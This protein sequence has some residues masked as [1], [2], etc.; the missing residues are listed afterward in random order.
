[1]NT[2]L[3]AFVLLTI[4]QITFS[5]DLDA[6][7]IRNNDKNVDQ[8]SG[9]FLRDTWWS[10]PYEYAWAMQFAEENMVVLDAACG[11]SHPFKW[12]LAEK[13][14]HVW[15]CDTDKR[16]CSISKIIQETFDDLGHSAKTSLCLKDDIFSKINLVCASILR[17]PQ[18]MPL[19]DRIFCIST[20]E[21]LSSLDRKKTLQEFKKFLAPDGFIVLTVDYP[22]ITPEVL[23]S[24]C[25]E[26]GLRMLGN[27]E[28]GFPSE[29]ALTSQGL[30]VY[31]CVLT[32]K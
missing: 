32:H 22:V 19:F 11:I 8:V 10:R 26:I 30:H 3:F 9:I 13:C 28:F 23:A 6:R 16:I 1:M 12:Y 4:S 15:A 20:L 24:C 27:V 2:K 14:S 21:H 17:L 25:N 29:Q 31:R 7:F 18:Y 5:Y